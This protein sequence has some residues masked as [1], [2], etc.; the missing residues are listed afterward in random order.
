M[1]HGLSKHPL[2][3]VWSD[4]KQRCYNKKNK[5]YK[6]Y[7][8]RGIIICDEWKNNLEKF[9]DWAIK[10][11]WESGLTIERIDVDKNYEPSNCTWIPKG[12]Q[13]AN[14]RVCTYITAFSER[15]TLGEWGKDQR[16]RVCYQ[17]IYRRILDGWEPELAITTPFF[18]FKDTKIE[19]F[20]EI[21]GIKDWPLDERCV[22][23]QQTLY[24]RIRFGKD[25]EW[26]IITPKYNYGDAVR[27]TGIKITAFGECKTISEWVVDNRCKVEIRALYNRLSSG[28][29]PEDA[30]SKPATITITAFGETKT[31]PEWSQD[32]RCSV[33]YRQL[34][35]R[36]DSGMSPEDAV[37]LP[38]R[39][40]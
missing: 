13:A 6:Y 28:M 7:G 12:K 3:P 21:K 31:I 25:A 40:N 5:N 15:K 8:E 24:D 29:N 38:K 33:K 9:I 19:A 23:D 16:S 2:R 37:S 14:R 10:N 4:I 26:S 22:V 18:T 30:I 39:K 35:S 27:G 32:D 34:K 11:G 17:I 20:G 36:L 1:K